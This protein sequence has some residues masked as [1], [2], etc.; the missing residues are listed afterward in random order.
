M[1]TNPITYPLIT[2][3]PRINS[4]PPPPSG[5]LGYGAIGRQ[6]ARV[7]T[8]LG[9]TILAFTST[10]R[11]T[12]SSRR[13]PPTVFNL[14]ALGDP[15]GVLP[16]EWHHGDVDAFL[17]QDLDLL[18]IALP[19]TPATAGLLGAAQFA[20][21]GRQRRAFVVN[22]ARGAIVDEDALVAALEAG[23]IRGAAVDVTDPEPLPAGRKLW[24]APNCFVTPH[25][26]WQSRS[27]RGRGLG[28][29]AGNVE[30]VLKGGVLVNELKR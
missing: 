27:Q 4:S 11:P 10:P 7:L 20:I 16:A 28:I 2:R 6:V 22:I 15:D 1:P 21:L 14:P 3:P 19:L 25:V 26:A 23:T 13:R 30:A 12:P 29:L 18:V 5:I 17:A 9:A 8:A 24:G